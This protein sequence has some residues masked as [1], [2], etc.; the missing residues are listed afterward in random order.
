MLF[1]FMICK[2]QTLFF[3]TPAFP[4]VLCFFDIIVCGT[5]F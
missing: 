3:A 2:K 1:L 4:Y 5:F